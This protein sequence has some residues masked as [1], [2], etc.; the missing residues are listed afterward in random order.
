MQDSDESK[1]EQL[2]EE[3]GDHAENFYEYVSE[4][5]TVLDKTLKEDQLQRRYYHQD[6]Q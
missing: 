6:Y 4:K 3:L 5:L 1:L 2:L